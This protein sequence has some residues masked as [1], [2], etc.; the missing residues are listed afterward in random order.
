MPRPYSA[1]LRER[2]VRAVVGGRSCRA[3]AA[4]FE[5]SVSFVI[6]LVQ[7]WKKQG[8]TAPDQFGGWKKFALAEHTEFVHALVER[9][10]D[11]T[12]EELREHL[13]RANIKVS[14]SALR[15]FLVS[16]GLTLK[17]RPHTLKNR[18]V[19]TSPPPEPNGA[20]GSPI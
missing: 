3:V 8:T 1:D 2:V 7:R 11:G 13:V 4:H 9:H 16:Q 5:V 18:N 17:K 14:Q 10:H 20:T 6:K 15:R 12:L 19:K